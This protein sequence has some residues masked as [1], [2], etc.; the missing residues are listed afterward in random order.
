MRG[1]QLPTQEFRT[2]ERARGLSGKW[3][4]R[5]DPLTKLIDFLRPPS[6]MHLLPILRKLRTLTQRAELTFEFGL[7]DIRPVRH[8]R[9]RRPRASLS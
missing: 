9:R 1:I 5:T 4:Q 6:L 8:R 3:L 7:V 2:L